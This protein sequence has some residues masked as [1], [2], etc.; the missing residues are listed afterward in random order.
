MG[1]L[2]DAAIAQAKQGLGAERFAAEYRRGTYLDQAGAVAEALAFAAEVAAAR[3]GDPG[4]D[5][6]PPVSAVPGARLTAREADVLRLV[7]TGRS[8]REIAGVLGISHQ[9]VSQHVK[10]A[11]RRLGAPSRT[12]AV[13]VAIRS[14]LLGVG[15]LASAPW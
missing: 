14:G 11:M 13:A 4:P 15:V 8:D 7:I 10:S 6:A 1:G 12:A 2:W 9:T 5:P 3:A